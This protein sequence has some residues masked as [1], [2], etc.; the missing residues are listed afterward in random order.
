MSIM[1]VTAPC[2]TLLPNTISLSPEKR[3]AMS[4]EI[5]AALREI[6]LLD[7]LQLDRRPTFAINLA[8][9]TDNHT[10]SGDLEIVYCNPSLRSTPD[11]Y[12]RVCVDS[13]TAPVSDVGFRYFKDWA[14]GCAETS[15][16]PD[17]PFLQYAGRTWSYIS[18]PEGFRIISAN[19]VIT[20]EHIGHD[21]S[22][23]RYEQ[24]LLR[25]KHAA[26]SRNA[27]PTAADMQPIEVGK[28]APNQLTKE[29]IYCDWTSVPLEN[30]TD[31]HKVFTRSVDWASTPLG[32]IEEWSW[33]L[34]SASDMTMRTPYPAAMYWGP[35]FITMYN[36][37]YVEIAGKKHPKLTG[38]PYREGWSEIWDDIKPILLRAWNEGESAMKREDRLFITRNGFLEETF[39]SWSMV[40]LLGSKNQVMGLFNAA[41][42]NTQQIVNERRLHT[43]REVGE[44][45]A[46]AKSFREFWALTLK[47]LEYNEPDVPFCLI[48]S[49]GEDNDSDSVSFNSGSLSFS[50]NLTLEGSLGV[51]KSH[52]AAPAIL[53]SRSQEGFAPYMRQSMAAGGVPILLSTEDD[54]LPKS[55]VQGF[56]WRG[57]GDACRHLVVFPINPIAAWYEATY[58]RGFVVLGVNPRRPYD[59]DYKLF[60]NLMMRQ[61]AT[62]LASVVLFE[63]EVRRSAKAAR[64]AAID[65]EHLSLQL[66]MRTQEAVESEYKFSRLAEF[67]P[68]GI[69]IADFEGSFSYCNDM[70]WQISRQNRV[71]DFGNTTKHAWIHNVMDADRP[72]LQAAWDKMIVEKSTMSI[73]FRFKCSQRVA[74]GII[75]TWV[76]MSAYPD[77]HQ[78]S[79]KESIFGCIT[80]ISSQKRAEQVQSDRRKEAVEL[81]RQQENFIDITSHEMRNPLSAIL[82]CVDQITSSVVE[83]SDY[84]LLDSVKRLHA[85]CLDAANTISLCAS[86][87]KRIVDDILTL[88]KLDSRLIS[89]TP[90]DVQPLVVV[91]QVLKMF[92]P[93]VRAHDINL[94]VKVDKSYH[95][96]NIDWVTLDPS[97]LQQVLINFITNSIKFTQNQ[98][99]R[100]ITVTMNAFT[101]LSKLL[102]G[103]IAYLECSEFSQSL[104]Q[105]RHHS[106]GEQNTDPPILLQFTIQDS[107]SGINDEDL[108]LLFRRFQQATPRTHVQYG[109]SGLGL[110]ISRTLVEM[111]GGQIG[112]LSQENEGSSFYFYV[113]C[114]KGVAQERPC[115]EDAKLPTLCPHRNILSLSPS[116]SPPK[117]R[118][119]SLPNPAVPDVP[120]VSMSS[121]TE[122]K[123]QVSS[124][125]FKILIVEDNLINQKVLNRQLINK[126][127]K[128]YT[129]NHG[130][131]ALELLA[132]S[133]FWKGRAAD[134]F[135]ISV[136]LM[137]L[138]MPV[139]DGLT[140]TKKIRELER[141]GT[142]VKHIPIIAVTAYARPEQVQKA[143]DAGMDEVMPKPFRM[144]D[145]IPKIKDIVDR[146]SLP[147]RHAASPGG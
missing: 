35:E 98:K 46:A 105:Q 83:F 84:G 17:V 67:A 82:Q 90:V 146:Y 123:E 89:V 118:S 74:D 134:G 103:D 3:D 117:G 130:Q 87:Q 113:K 5:P 68:V 33:D 80:D 120:A 88:S 78:N 110:F 59:D 55:L 136:I 52:P 44:H 36:K 16:E 48:Y 69:F 32:P 11:I 127:N 21:N 144:T 137:D 13:K 142:I 56:D 107:G 64:L 10:V 42:E 34:R 49:V 19:G 77:S 50:H 25:D 27:G 122:V 57:F 72:K 119:I 86:H 62:S 37:S 51:P 7:L 31:D 131:E 94:S 6:K 63:E 45:T 40:P 41:F 108:K 22:P 121:N 20:Q 140:C 43:L 85:D 79:K 101:D 147:G 30:E 65:R 4:A 124:P 29:R 28:S 9:Y 92:Q 129:A 106:S 93:E 71:E 138:E 1:E 102:Q 15:S 145:L 132:K 2:L 97:R 23:S 139:M 26:F 100:N 114:G 116:P 12:N 54:T 70:W 115:N 18:L 60:V 99:T 58:P 47:G 133:R 126:G 141:E 104:L 24:R 39:F 75:D 91:E 128:T 8:R 53:D 111:Q 135:D 112:V 76:L 61:L 109:G 125:Q 14:L 66:Q 96:S 81:K 38:Q 73:E 143:Q 95:E